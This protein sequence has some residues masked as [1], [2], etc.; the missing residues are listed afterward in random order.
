M[1]K[2]IALTLCLT[3]LSGC[4]SAREFNRLAL[5]IGIGIDYLENGEYKVTVQ[6][7]KT[8][9]LAEK[10]SKSEDRYLN[11]VQYGESIQIAMTNMELMLSRELY[12]GQT[13]LV[14]ICIDTAKSAYGLEGVIDY[15]YRT[16]ESRFSVPLLINDSKSGELLAID[17]GNE[18]LPAM[19]VAG[20]LN[21]KLTDSLIQHTTMTDFLCSVISPYTA[22]TIPIMGLTDDN[23]PI[24]KG[25]AIFDDYVMIGQ[26]DEALTRGMLV[27]N[28]EYSGGI[29]QLEGNKNQP[30]MSFRIVKDVI[31]R[32]PKYE[33]GKFSLEL[34]GF[35]RCVAEEIPQKVDLITEN[36]KRSIEAQLAAAGKAE[37]YKV[38]DAAKELNADIFYFGE[39]ILNKYPKEAAE[40]LENWEVEFAN[41]PIEINITMELASSGSVNGTIQ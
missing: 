12:T 18:V 31:R 28:D 14:N 41:L 30:P 23:I 40:L 9:A 36:G 17:S 35:F 6:L 8:S 11:A 5:V 2:I 4:W 1:K 20:I 25:M 34:E 26:I 3:L 33:D 32:I 39:T 24:L 19:R 22:P 13:Q 29:Q 10:G 15:F 21:S 27:I 37:L 16:S 7:A 38:I